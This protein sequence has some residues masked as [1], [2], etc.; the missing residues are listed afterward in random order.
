[1]QFEILES[2]VWRPEIPPYP[3]EEDEDKDDMP[4]WLPSWLED[5]GVVSMMPNA[6]IRVSIP[7]YPGSSN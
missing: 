3:I 1:M 7:L 6:H 2:P 4:V 5:N